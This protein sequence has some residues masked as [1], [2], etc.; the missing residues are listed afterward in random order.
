[1][2]GW[3]G[4]VHHRSILPRGTGA[5]RGP[6]GRRSRHRIP[7]QSRRGGPVRGS[8]RLQGD[9]AAR[10]TRDGAG[11]AGQPVAGSDHGRRESLARRAGPPSR[12]LCDRRRRHHRKPV[13][14]HRRTRLLAVPGRL[15]PADRQPARS[16]QLR[17]GQGA[18]SARRGR[19]D[20][21]RF[22]DHATDR[23]VDGRP[24]LDAGG[25]TDAQRRWFPGR[26]RLRRLRELAVADPQ[27]RGSKPVRVQPGGRLQ[28]CAAGSGLRLPAGHDG[29]LSLLARTGNGRLPA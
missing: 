7:D 6:G 15:R 28:R 8:R 18:G 1:M 3:L 19:P 25:P 4:Q 23:S 20:R 11:A 5:R 27:Q 24:N 9:C 12:E 29:R 16:V 13:D 2:E 14:R 26:G 22:H 17:P 21:L 10:C